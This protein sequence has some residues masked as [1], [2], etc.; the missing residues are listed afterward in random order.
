MN[1]LQIFRNTHP[2]TVLFLFIYALIL[3]LH[4]IVFFE[5]VVPDPVHWQAPL[6]Q[7]LFTIIS[8]IQMG[9]PI[10]QVLGIIMLFAGAMI[11][12]RYLNQWKILPVN[13]YVPAVAYILTGSF[14]DGFILFSPLSLTAFL[15]ILAFTR[16][17]RFLSDRKIET[18]L[19]DCGFFV[20]MAAL[21]YVPAFSFLI[22][23]GIAIGILY[24]LTFRKS[25]V[26][27]SGF[28]VPF[29]CMTAYSFWTDNLP[30]YTT[31][32]FHTLQLNYNWG[33]RFS[34]LDWIKIILVLAIMII[35]FVRMMVL[36]PKEMIQIRNIITII[37]LIVPFGIWGL[38][39]QPIEPYYF[40]LFLLPLSFVLC[41]QF[42][43]LKNKQTAEAVHTVLILI[44]ILSQYFNFAIF[45]SIP[46]IT[47]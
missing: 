44:L 42:I 34:D 39:F 45:S 20:G 6:S 47:R 15:L 35:A 14:I 1:V 40:I 29:I 46:F 8:D 5:P 24:Q 3:N 4:Y 21:L 38:F 36:Y 26:I 9:F 19:F 28:L 12:N 30:G 23:S 27:L 31:G 7:L 16:L 22:W 13:T 10:Q 25:L 2:I 17:F 11:F 37:M 18:S 41:Y 43:T 32:L 33:F